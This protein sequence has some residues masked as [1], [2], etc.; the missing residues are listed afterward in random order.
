MTRNELFEQIK[1]GELNNVY[2]FYGQEVY[3]MDNAVKNIKNRLEK[4]NGGQIDYINAD[5]KNISSEEIIE[6]CCTVSF[7]S[8]VK[9]IVVEDFPALMNKDAKADESIMAYIDDPQ[10]AVLIF[11]C[12]SDVAKTSA[13][14]KKL[15]TTA[16]TVD[17]SPLSDNELKIFINR[18]LNKYGKKISASEL[19]FL[20]QYTDTE[21]NSLLNELNKLELSSEDSSITLDDIENIVT[22]SREYKIFKLTDYIMDRNKSQAVELI[23]LLLWQKEDPIFIV[24]V[25]SKTLH[26]CL[27]AKYKLNEKRS[28][29]EIAKELGIKDFAV[30]KIMA[31][32][33]KYKL[34]QIENCQDLLLNADE[35]LKSSSVDGREILTVLIAEIIANLR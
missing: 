23:D 16:C 13:L 18:E 21:L 29:A 19:D 9:L 22:P 4:E 2:L 28:S 3:L 1:K 25:I 8:P 34:K 33:Q 14:Y 32:C 12:N 35:A 17:F 31:Y 20:I 30:K 10:D 6:Y 11:L 15:L 26:N 24:A 27:I 7:L 5:G